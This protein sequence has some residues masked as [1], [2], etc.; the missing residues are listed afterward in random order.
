MRLFLTKYN[1]KR[2]TS[3]D[4]IA[5]TSPSN[6]AHPLEEHL[7]EV[8]RLAGTFAESFHSGAWGHLAGL[9]HDLGKYHRE[10]QDYIRQNADAH[11]EDSKKGRV[12][13]S[14]A[15]ALHAIDCLGIG[16]GIILA[17]LIAGHHTGLLDWVAADN[18]GFGASPLSN[19]INNEKEKGRLTELKRDEKIPYDML[20]SGNFND[21][22]PA[23]IDRDFGYSL[24][25]RML[26]SCL[27]DADFLD[28]ERYMNS[29]KAAHRGGYGALPDL[30]AAFDTHMEKFAPDTDVNKLRADILRQCHSSGAA[31]PPGLF[32]LTVP[33]GGGK[34]LAAMGFALEHALRHG[35]Q[36]IIYVIPYTSIIEQTAEIFRSIFGDNVVEHHSNVA[37]LDPEQENARSRLAC[38][39]WDAPI[40]VTTSVQ[41]FES[42]F[43]ARTS[44]VRK[45]HNIVNSVVIFDEAQLLPVDFLKPILKATDTLAKS[46][47]ASIV[48]STATQPALGRS[49][50]ALRNHGLDNVH[51]IVD[52][53]SGLFEQL[54]RVVFEV[55]A[56]LEKPQDWES[57]TER[58]TQHPSVLC[59][60][61]RRD[62]A[63]TLYKM[64]RQALP[65]EETGGL[66]HLSA[67]MC[68]AHRSKKIARIKE[69]LK[70]GEPTR[71]VS[72][73]LIWAGAVIPKRVPGKKAKR[74]F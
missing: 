3:V 37:F 59:I 38:E 12:D 61:N 11:I 40:I 33:T 8:A 2:T 35:K 71:V 54:K 53:P 24:W 9:W 47:G 52:N 42:L 51:E 4:Y 1:P 6:T 15:G 74:S 66:F 19:R 29:D 55:P 57:V 36:R 65:P 60:V 17:Y 73:Q 28:T 21:G 63:R 18:A 10:F 23:G 67:L 56:D 27:V 5:H 39:N 14:T 64:L 62:D 46:F 45:L 7:Q 44:H 16:K 26:F 58:L 70:K 48:F 41:F 68:G 31:L 30:K 69:R 50:P 13:H 34:T 32:S 20:D 49:N 43:A 25:L 22:L 72:T